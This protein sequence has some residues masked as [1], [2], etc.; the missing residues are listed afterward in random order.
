ME[1]DVRD[2]MFYSRSTDP[3]ESGYVL[4]AFLVLVAILA[5]TVSMFALTALNNQKSVSASLDQETSYQMARAGLS[6]WMGKVRQDYQDNHKISNISQKNY[7]FCDNMTIVSLAV[8]GQTRRKHN[9]IGAGAAGPADPRDHYV[10]AWGWGKEVTSGADDDGDT[11]LLGERVFLPSG[12]LSAQRGDSGYFRLTQVEDASGEIAQTADTMNCKSPVA[13][14]IDT[15]PINVN[16]ASHTFLQQIPYDTNPVRYLTA[17]M[18]SAI[19]E[20]RSGSS[21]STNDPDGDGVIE[22]NEEV[23]TSSADPFDPPYYED[24][25]DLLD[26]MGNFD[27]SST[28]GDNENHCS[29]PSKFRQHITTK[30]EQDK[31]CATVRG[32]AIDIKN[33]GAIKYGAEP[34]YD[35]TSMYSLRAKVQRPAKDADSEPV[36]VLTIRDR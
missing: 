36:R 10:D 29:K 20:Y 2:P 9:C 17:N 30:S 5:A 33:P 12:E 31:F 35:V 22:L 16:T 7:P 4:I 13:N 8:G 11:L 23:Y 19:I 25:C 15:G 32:A 24:L 6:I 27:G 14:S 18:A 21:E 26:G 28:D 1:R 34:D 3:A